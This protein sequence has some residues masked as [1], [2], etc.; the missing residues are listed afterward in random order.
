MP[1]IKEGE[2]EDEYVKR[3]IPIRIAEGNSPEQAEAACHGMYK[4][5]KEKGTN[6]SAEQKEF[7]F[8][9]QL[10]ILEKEHVLDSSEKTS[11]ITETDEWVK[12]RATAIVGNR[13][14]NGYFVSYSELK[15]SLDSWNGTLHDISHLGTSYPDNTPPFKRENIDYIIGYQDNAEA[16]DKTKE[17]SMDV[18]VYK[19]SE[20]YKSWKSFID[21]N[22]KANKTPNVSVSMTATPKLINVGALEKADMEDYGF[23]GDETVISL[24][25]IIPKAL[26]TCIKGA[27]DDKKGCGLAHNNTIIERTCES[28][29]NCNCKNDKPSVGVADEKMSEADT[30]KLAELKQRIKNLKEEKNNE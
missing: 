7:T 17:I 25:D 29:K 12:I 27:C 16:N 13:M 26:T 3:C 6:Y 11:P 20:K 1:S 19:K 15:K 9:F 23:K 21:I 30:K 28:C 14:M 4:S 2:S 24:C 8:T 18:N 10:D 5:H 22:K